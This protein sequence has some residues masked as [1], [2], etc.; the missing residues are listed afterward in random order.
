MSDLAARW[1]SRAWT[2]SWGCVALATV[3]LMLGKLE[4][5]HWSQVVS[6][7]LPGWLALNAL[8]KWK[9]KSE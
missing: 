9:G 4:A 3:L 5:A 8:E 2:L 6:I 7:A 1:L